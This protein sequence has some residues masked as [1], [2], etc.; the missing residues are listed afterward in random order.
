VFDFLPPFLKRLYQSFR[1]PY[2]R[3]TRVR[4]APEPAPEIAVSMRERM[5]RVE[6]I[7]DAFCERRPRPQRLFRKPTGHRDLYSWCDL[8]ASRYPTTRHRC[9]HCT[10]ARDLYRRANQGDWQAE[11]RLHRLATRASIRLL[12]QRRAWAETRRRQRAARTPEPGPPPVIWAMLGWKRWRDRR[13]E[14]PPATERWFIVERREA[15]AKLVRAHTRTLQRMS[16]RS[17]ARRRDAALARECD[18]VG[19]TISTT[20]QATDAPAPSSR[21][22]QRRGDPGQRD[23]RPSR[24]PGSPRRQSAARDDGVHTDGLPE[25]TADAAPPQEALAPVAPAVEP[26][27]APATAPAPAEAAAAEAAA[28]PEAPAIAPATQGAPAPA[29]ARFVR[30]AY[31]PGSTTIIRIGAGRWT[32]PPPAR[33]PDLSSPAPTAALRP[34]AGQGHAVRAHRLT[35]PARS[36]HR[37][38]MS[39]QPDYRDTV[40][41]PRTGF[42]MRGDL[43]KREPHLLARWD[44]MDLYARLREASR[45]RQKFILHDGPPYANG[46]IHIG[47]GLN[48]ILKDFINRTRQ[49]AG[50]D[51]HYIPG[52]DCHGLPIEWRIEEQYRRDGRDKDAVPVLDF[53]AE[54]RAYAQH[55]MSVQQTEFRRLGVEGGWRERYATMDAPSEAAIA[56]EIGRFLLNGAL[57][58]GLRPVMWSPVEKTALAEAEIEYHDHTST[59]I[60]VR[61]PIVAAPDRAL[62]GA[63]VVIWTTT[64]WTI[65]GNRALAG[66]SEI[67]YA[68]IHVDAVA[69]VSLARVGERM[70]V[71]LPL[72]PGFVETAGIATHHVVHMLTGANLAG[73]IC[74]HP[75]RGRGYDFDVPLFLDHFVTTDAGTGFVHIAPGH[76]EDDFILGRAHG[77][78]I[79]ET[80]GDDGTF[81]AWVPLFAGA[82]VYKAADPVCAA[83]T[84]AGML[85]AR[86]RLVHSY[87]HSWR[88]R[89][90][91]IFRATPQWF[92][93]MDG[94]QNI[95]GRALDAIAQTHFVPESGRNRIGSMIAARPDWCISRQRAWGVPIAV[96]V[97]KRTGE[98]L[99]D[100][101]IVARVVEAFT[102][103]GADAWYASP[104]SRFLGPGRDPG[105]Y[106]QVFDIVDV[107]F[108]SGST[109]AFVL[110]ARGLPWPADL[111]LE[112][113]DQHRGWFHSSLLEAVGTRGRAPFRA[114]LTHGFVLDEQGRKMSKSLGNVVA[115]QEVADTLGAD[116]LR[117][118]TVMSDTADDLRIGKEI[119]KQTTETY[120]RLRNTLRWLLGSL[121]GFTEAERV[122]HA[123]M[124]ELERWVLHRLTELDARIRGATESYDWTGVYPE[125]HAFCASDLSAFYFD[126]RKDALYCD[127]PD[128]LRRR[129]SR[130]VLD[131]LHRCLTVWLAP[132]L[133]FTAE[134]A[135][136]ARF[137]EADSVHLQTFP[138]LPEIWRDE[139]LA[140]RWAELRG[141]RRLVTFATET[142]RK[143]DGLGSSLE[144]QVELT[145]PASSQSLDEN[146]WAE[147]CIVSQMKL[148]EGPE[149][150][151]AYKAAGTKCVRCWRVLPEVGSVAAHPALCLR[152]AD[153]VDSGLVCRAAA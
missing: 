68:L 69:D 12:A 80:I 98:P 87:P 47:T 153:A 84:D 81:N 109:H 76:G 83:L 136:C 34:P 137:G 59:T 122:D 37:P 148:L 70:L 21:G 53:R 111:Y 107:W 65:P 119:L 85:V 42:P 64:P 66:G 129:A 8:E 35:P 5:F 106:E 114:V 27:D 140:T 151:S 46:N 39:D 6:I 17:R 102:A 143:Q 61:F 62:V 146:G 94:E 51:A 142:A 86:G 22:A 134:D 79:P 48:K 141:I 123:Q 38:R 19:N 93:R 52:W 63:S 116:I 115:P 36:P 108:E 56:A 128:S 99:R 132:A 124:P 152:C 1:V 4:A 110:E 135:W 92:I 145:L 95:R 147:V 28:Q 9:A 60:W 144:M 18:V 104:A 11:V 105:D 127:R 2:A 113:T 55:W 71:A 150:A 23:K 97:D 77:I 40:F 112:G 82:H 117:L 101:D 138:D 54:C 67:E 15:E 126:V 24:G 100:P 10:D 118:W 96:F 131:H 25:P 89:A 130:T 29:P 58:R 75:L 14:Y 49:M 72:L 31:P 57:Y 74:A 139:V 73:V 91:L 45:Q 26:T 149:G 90:P 50:Q 32:I 30:V 88:S 125:L 44:R 121:D 133:C 43:P 41:L 7:Q 78:D 13:R 103:E 16:Q 120:R 3:G 20:E 33:R